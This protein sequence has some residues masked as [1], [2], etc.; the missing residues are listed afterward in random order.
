MRVNGSCR[1]GLLL[2]CSWVLSMAALA[3][4]GGQVATTG[5]GTRGRARGEFIEPNGIAVDQQTGDIFVLDSDNSRIEKFTSE[6]AFLSAWGWGVADGRTKALQTC[7]ERCFAGLEGP[8][9]GE[10]QFAEG[11]AV[12]NDPSSPSHGDVYVVDIGNHRIEKFSPSGAFLLMIGNGVNDTAHQGRYYDE[13]NRCP[14]NPDDICG[15]GSEDPS[16]APLASQLEFAVEGDFIA[17]GPEGI[18]YVGQRN[19]VKEFTPAGIYKEQIGLVP[20]PTPAGGREVGGVSGLAVNGSGDLYVIRHG[21]VGVDEYAPSGKLLRTLEQ[22]GEPAAPE[23]PTPSLALDP[24]GDVF[25]DVHMGAHHRID[26][27]S[28]RGVR[29]ASFDSGQEDGLHGLAYD[30]HTR[31][32][33]IVNTNSDIEPPLARVRIVRPPRP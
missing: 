16:Q 30:E 2:T 9:A 22:G 28:S 27:Y 20:A 29:L 12:D 18:L 32:L 26:E 31:E 7:R 11:I 1:G 14:V 23:G 19:R 33:Y 3:G 10:L 24:A 25:I 5:F 6:G 13:E 17:V 15:P 21:I 8:G 4:C